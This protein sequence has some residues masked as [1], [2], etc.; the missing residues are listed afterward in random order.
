VECLRICR[1]SNHVDH[2]REMVKDDFI[3]YICKPTNT[4]RRDVRP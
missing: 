4:W 3:D 2:H 1:T